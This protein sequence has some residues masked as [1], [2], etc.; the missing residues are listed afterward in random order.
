M[1]LEFFLSRVAL[2]GALAIIAGLAL[3]A[4]VLVLF[5]GFASALVLLV[6]TGDYRHR[7][8]YASA[9]TTVPARRREALPLAG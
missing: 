3:D 9:L 4:F 8:G 5:A 6:A 2:I 7:R 1:K